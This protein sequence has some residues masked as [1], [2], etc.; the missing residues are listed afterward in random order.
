MNFPFL[1]KLI[2]SR[3]RFLLG[4]IILVQDVSPTTTSTRLSFTGQWHTKRQSLLTCF[5]FI[6]LFLRRRFDLYDHIK[7]KKLSAKKGKAL[8]SA[9][10][11]EN[12]QMASK[13]SLTSNSKNSARKRPK[14]NSL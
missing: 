12:Q 2:L 1:S 8:D 14:A 4:R 3:F 11:G 10:F 6:E 5:W 7:T 13:F 9:K